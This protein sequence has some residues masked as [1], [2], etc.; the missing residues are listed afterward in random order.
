MR[1]DIDFQ[2]K[3]FSQTFST[4]VEAAKLTTIHRR[5]FIANEIDYGKVCLEDCVYKLSFPRHIGSAT[6]IKQ[7]VVKHGIKLI[8]GFISNTDQTLGDV[9]CLTDKDDKARLFD[10]I[11]KDLNKYSLVFALDASLLE[12]GSVDKI[13]ET[14]FCMFIVTNKMIGNNTPN[15]AVFPA[16]IIIE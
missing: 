9:F 10:L 5:H 7:E 6:L 16:V 12:K 8:K 1:T 11:E 15:T 13:L 3:L 2:R 14:L 4:I